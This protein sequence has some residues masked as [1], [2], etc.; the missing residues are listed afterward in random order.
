MVHP[1]SPPG[2]MASGLPGARSCTSLWAHDRRPVRAGGRGADGAVRDDVASLYPY[3][4]IQPLLAVE[5][6]W[7]DLAPSL[8]VRHIL[9]FI[10]L[11]IGH[12]GNAHSGDFRSP[13]RLPRK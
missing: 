10:T 6:M 9:G 7:L 8:K 13:Y 2:L 5:E 12:T 1:F 3:N 4:P 11:R